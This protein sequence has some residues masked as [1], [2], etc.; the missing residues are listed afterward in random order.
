MIQTAFKNRMVWMFAAATMVFCMAMEAI[1]A[2]AADRVVVVPLGGQRGAPVAKTGQT[3]SYRTGDDG[4]LQKGV[5]VSGRFKDHNN[6]TVTDGLT[7]LIW[8]K[9]GQCLEFFQNDP[10][11]AANARSWAEAIDSANKL[12]SGYCGLN[13]SSKAGDWRLP[14]WKELGSLIDLGQVNP[15]MPEDC[16][17]AASTTMFF[18]YWMSTTYAVSVNSAWMVNFNNGNDS[19]S[20]KSNNHYVRPVRGGK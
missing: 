11:S 9:D 17:L 1:P 10:K 14:N 13:D 8:L 3:T 7:G 18:Y 6:G 5:S 2:Q 19:T 12:A 15:A 4:D 20:D 16:P